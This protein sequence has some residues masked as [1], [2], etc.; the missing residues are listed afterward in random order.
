MSVS[1]TMQL[2]E[3]Q[4]VRI[5]LELGA[6]NVGGALSNAELDRIRQATGES[7]SFLPLWLP[8]ITEQLHRNADPLGDLLCQVRTTTERRRTGLVLTP[9]ELIQPMVGWVA[10]QGAR[11]VVDMGSGS[12]RFAVAA[13]A[14]MQDAYIVAIDADPVATL[15]TRAA[16]SVQGRSSVEV[17]Q[18]N[19]LEARLSRTE[20][21]TAFVGNP[22][23]VRHHELGQRTKGW[24][25][26][27]AR[28]LGLTVSGLAGLHAYFFLATALHAFDGDIGCLVTSAEWLDVNYG[29]VIRDLLVG[30]LGLQ[31]LH[32]LDPTAQP[33]ADT[34]TTAAVSCFC[35]GDKSK[36]VSL[37]PIERVGELGELAANRDGHDVARER[38]QDAR[39][40]TPLLRAKQ[41]IPE[42]YIELGEL[43]RVH[44][45]AV[46][47][48]NS[49]WITNSGDR[50]LPPHVLFPAVT[51]ARE[52]FAAGDRLTNDTDLKRV[53]DLPED[54]DLLDPA[55]R[56]L[57]EAFLTR[58]ERAGAAEGYIARYRRAWWSVG[59]KPAAPILATYMA[60]RPPTF[61]RNLVDAR[62]IN[63]AHGLYPRIDLP[64]Q[65][66]DRLA[67]ALRHSVT[68][69][70]GR[71][72]AG[73][74]TKFE[75]KEMERLP[76][77]DLSVLLAP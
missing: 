77:P 73:G 36:F 32:V 9:P 59:L 44:R 21:R 54:L 30:R 37:R 11:R 75:P 66:L 27:A 51:R 41:D 72:Y 62:H 48:Q 76:V 67:S 7:A 70:Q 40:W 20:G 4:L 63:I 38:L 46:T 18:S 10:S 53:I 19:Y 42:G 3:D 55:D 61:V 17:L 52:L 71:T 56:R 24:A 8:S 31:S 23:Y 28:P 57:V 22:P 2:T 60:R 39:R 25:Q 47:G 35:V 65:A 13:A 33:F 12:G 74:L 68:V 29:A 34:A 43:C 45:G 16:L 49:V 69:A 50:A 26:S 5:A 58:A 64:P 6:A 15:L 1:P 14:A